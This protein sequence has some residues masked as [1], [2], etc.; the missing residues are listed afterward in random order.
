MLTDD[1]GYI[2]VGTF[3]FNTFSEFISAISKLKSEGAAS[4]VID[5]RGNVG[6]SLET[7]VAMVNEFLDRGDLIVYAEGRSFPRTDHYANGSGTM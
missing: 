3:A 2:K 4:F 6:G 5:L 1:I 7:V